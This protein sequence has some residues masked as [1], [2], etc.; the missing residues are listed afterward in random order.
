MTTTSLC[1]CGPAAAPQFTGRISDPR[2]HCH[3]GTYLV[4]T[5]ARQLLD[6]L[7]VDTNPFITRYK[8]EPW[9]NNAGERG[10]LDCE[11]V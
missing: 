7:M 8:K 5:G 10:I 2:W 4:P 1:P 9:Y 6:V 11:G 3:N